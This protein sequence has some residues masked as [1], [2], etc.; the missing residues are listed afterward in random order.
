[1]EDF[2]FKVVAVMRV[3]A[4]DKSAA[5]K[6]VPTSMVKVYVEVETGAG[7]DA[8]DHRPQL[9]A[10]LEDARRRR[11]AV[12]VAKLDRLSRDVAFISSLVSKRVRFIVAELGADADAFT[13]HIFAA[14]YDDGVSAEN[15]EDVV[16]QLL[17]PNFWLTGWKT[18][19]SAPEI[20]IP[21]LLIALTV[22]W[23]VKG[24]LD[25]G[26]IKGV[27]AQRD[28]ANE[29]LHFAN[30]QRLA[31]PGE[32][33]ETEVEKLRT[34]VTDLAK[35]IEAGAQRDELIRSAGAVTD[36]LTNL[37]ASNDELRHELQRRR[38]EGGW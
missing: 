11:C 5:R 3:R 25:E 16:G 15:G 20:A 29:R 26:E 9:A 8:L 32:A 33:I 27:K 12:I 31:A 19:W 18:F 17:D 38:A 22:G 36:T 2:A 24:A 37:S 6:V 7:A 35:K 14:M 34:Q 4:D 13:I 10:A 23:K 30:E 1:M 28:T 21:L